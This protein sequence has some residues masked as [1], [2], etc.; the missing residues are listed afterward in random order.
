RVLAAPDTRIDAAWAHAQA[1]DAA[2][3]RVRDPLLV[4][5]SGRRLIHGEGDGCPGLVIDAYADTAVVVFDGVAA[6]AFWRPGLADVIAGIEAAGIALAHVWV[7]ADRGAKR[8]GDGGEGEALRGDPPAEITI[9]EDEARF[10][11]DVRHGQKTGFFLDQRENRRTVRK[12]AAGATVLN[13]FS[14]SGGFSLHAA[15]GG[16]TRV[17]SVDI[18]PPAIAALSR[19]VALS[20]LDALAHEG[21]VADVFDFLVRAAKQRRRWDLVICDPPSFAPSERAKPNALAAY[22]KLAVAALAV[23]EPGGRFALASCSSHVTETELL[24]MLAGVDPGARLRLS[25]GAASDHPVVPGFAEG[26][27]LKFLLFDV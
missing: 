22:R 2:A 11:V 19:N 21:V 18:A 12:H 27:Y 1:R 8:R 17:T 23:T 20:G 9:S 13:L 3:R 16:A 4:G 24:A 15:L 7:R 5:C 25:A 6:S 26:R 10:I 14:Y